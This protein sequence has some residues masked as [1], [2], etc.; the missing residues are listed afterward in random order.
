MDSSKNK[1]LT[2]CF[3]PVPSRRLGLSLGVDILPHKVCNLDCIYC[4]LGPTL[5]KTCKKDR[6]RPIEPIQ[7]ELEGLLKRGIH[8]DTLTITASGEPTLHEDLGR[9]VSFAK[10]VLKIGRLALLT[11]ATLLSDPDVRNAVAQTDILLPSLDAARETS[12]RRVN[13]PCQELSIQRIIQGLHDLQLEYKGSMWLEVLLVKGINDAP[14][15]ID[16]LKQ[17]VNFIQPAKVQLN[18]VNRP[19]AVEWAKPLSLQELQAIQGA[20]GGNTEIIADFRIKE[21]GPAVWTAGDIS[22][23]LTR[24]PMDIHALMSVTQLDSKTLKDM[25]QDM[26]DTGMLQRRILE[27][28]TFYFISNSAELPRRPVDASQQ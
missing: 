20:L 23:M 26:E 7:E 9:L 17:A 3:G 11:N 16:A 27:G 10:D 4:E 8:F 6:Y 1:P 2:Y 19:P 25:L 18:T 28:K 22:A 24:R 5:Q 13:R 14:E 15:D 12:F 21:R